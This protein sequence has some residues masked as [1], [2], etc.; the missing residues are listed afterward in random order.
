MRP[1][2]TLALPL[3]A[4]TCACTGSSGTALD[5]GSSDSGMRSESSTS[6][7]SST[8][9]DGATTPRDASASDASSP[10]DATVEASV[11]SDPFFALGINVPTDPWP[12]VPFGT[13]RL[14]DSGVA[15]AQ[16]ETSDAGTYDFS[17]LDT[18]LA[19]AQSHGVEVLYTFGRTPSFASSQPSLSCAE[20]VGECAPPSDLAAD[21][22]GT[23]AYFKT[24]VAALLAHVGTKIAYY[25]VWNEAN[26]VQFWVGT[27]PQ[28]VRL[29][30]DLRGAVAAAGLP[31]TVL[32]PSMCNCDNSHLT[33][34]TGTNPQDGMA[35]YL[36]TALPKSVGKGT[37]ASLAEGIAFHP[38]LGKPAPEGIVGLTQ[39]MKTTMSKY[40]AGALPLWDTESSWGK[41]ELITGCP[42]SGL[43]PFSST[44]TANMADFASRSLTLAHCAGIHRFSWYQWDNHSEGTLWEKA[45]GTLPAGKAYARVETWLSGAKLSP[46]VNASGTVWTC[47]LGRAG[48]Y[49]AEIVWDTAGPSSFTPGSTFTQYES[50]SGVVTKLGATVTLGTSPL[51][52]ENRSLP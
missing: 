48:G 23:N 22:T 29:A 19:A 12:S 41:N 35:F 52:L 20:G 45:D 16:L 7:E 18:W 17:T 40:D 5:G 44:C 14:W 3:L 28:L 26:N 15:W 6:H 10:I 32:T 8:P 24:F 42:T 2:P 33:G 25:E 51:L 47:T 43:A 27:A 38:Y 9:N 31:A 49:E 13:L 1:C 21:G 4:L 39:S 30:Y 37:G 34:K 11:T 36:A 50:L 46:C